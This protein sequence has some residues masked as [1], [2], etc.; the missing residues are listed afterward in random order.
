MGISYK[1]RVA[2]VLVFLDGT[3]VGAIRGTNNGWRYQPRGSRSFGDEFSTLNECKRS[4]ETE[5]A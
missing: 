4:L 1:S 3:Q 2:G 5:I